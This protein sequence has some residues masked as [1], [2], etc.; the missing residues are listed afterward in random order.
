MAEP[1]EH[2]QFNSVNIRG[3]ESTGPEAARSGTG[4]LLN[5]VEVTATA[6]EINKLD[7]IATT[8][9][10]TVTEGISFTEDGTSTTLTGTV[11][12]PAGAI[13]VDI[14][15]VITALFDDTGAVTMTVGD[16][17]DAD[18]WFTGINMKATDLLVG[19][20]LSAMHGDLWGGKEGAYLA[21]ATGRRGRTTAG[22]DSGPYYGAASE[23]IGVVT[24]TNQDGSAG[25]AFMFV[26]YAVPTVV[27][28]T[29]A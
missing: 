15:V 19:E 9:Y 14:R 2:T 24:T 22:V 17:D 3:V 21:A 18:G 12:I 4:L 29:G 8:A 6:A 27:A 5:D 16:D 26:T 13:L 10:A 25:R 20:V 11:E 23:V 1:S 7:G 28:A